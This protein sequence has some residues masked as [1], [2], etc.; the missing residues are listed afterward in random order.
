MRSATELN[1]SLVWLIVISMLALWII[2]IGMETTAASEQI[3]YLKDA[4]GDS[5]KPEDFPWGEIRE[6]L[7]GDDAITIRSNGIIRSGEGYLLLFFDENFDNITEVILKYSKGYNSITGS[8]FEYCYL[9]RPS[10]RSYYHHGAWTTTKGLFDAETEENVTLG[11][12]TFHLGGTIKGALRLKMLSYYIYG[13]EL[14]TLKIG[15]DTVPDCSWEIDELTNPAYIEN[16]ARIVNDTRFLYPNAS[17]L[18]EEPLPPPPPPPP[19]IIDLAYGFISS[20]QDWV[21]ENFA[22]TILLSIFSLAT[23]Y[24]ITSKIR[25]ILN[26]A[27]AYFIITILIYATTFR[28]SSFLPFLLS[29]A[30]VVPLFLWYRGV[31]T[32]L[33][34]VLNVQKRLVWIE[35]FV[36]FLS[37]LA[38]RFYVATFAISVPLETPLVYLVIL[39]IVLIRGNTLDTYGFKMKSFAKSF[40]IGLAYCLTY[41]LPFFV[42]LSSLIFLSTGQ[43]VFSAYNATSALIYLPFMILCV[44]LSEEGLFRGFMQTRLAKA[45]SKNTGLLVQA[46]L[47]AAWQLPIFILPLSVIG[48]IVSISQ[49]FAFGLIS[50]LFYKKSGNL[51]P[52]IL[53]NGFMNTTILFVTNRFEIYETEPFFSTILG[54]SVSIGLIIQAIFT[55]Y[56]AKKACV[57]T[58]TNNQGGI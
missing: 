18:M 54:V 12:M 39:T 48:M 28:T 26:V 42:T 53:A 43:I 33:S 14:T 46:M 22:S 6:V 41:G 23:I 29:T 15:G 56:L 55:K 25:A 36:L 50:G 32:S 20:I 31:S 44:G 17:F 51:I 7:I 27:L 21:A 30:L 13:R 19:T 1:S 4:I 52:L 5:T 45:Y 38:I 8:I 57:E 3:R 10:N 47:F 37:T 34:S 16:L 2:A 35:V 24:S 11:Q 58:G 9:Y 49:T 40:L